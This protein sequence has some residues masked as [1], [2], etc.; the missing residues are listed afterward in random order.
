MRYAI[1]LLNVDTVVIDAGMELR[2]VDV[3]RL[4]MNNIVANLLDDDHTKKLIGL[5][6][7]KTL[8]R[9]RKDSAERIRIAPHPNGEPMQEALQMVFG[10]ELDEVINDQVL[11]LEGQDDTDCTLG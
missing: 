9:L 4:K 10:E 8:Y 3:L 11:A 2:E 5:A 6:K 1:S 7:T